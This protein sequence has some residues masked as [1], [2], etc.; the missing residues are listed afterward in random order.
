MDEGNKPFTNQITR[1]VGE[2]STLH[3]KVAHSPILA[4]VFT[5]SV[6]TIAAENKPRVV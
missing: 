4:D 2:Q 1:A 3:E 5:G 6:F